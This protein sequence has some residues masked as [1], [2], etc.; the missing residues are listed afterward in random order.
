MLDPDRF[1]FLEGR[2]TGTTWRDTPATPLPINN[3][4]VLHLLEALQIEGHEDL[5]DYR[6]HLLIECVSRLRKGARDLVRMRYGD[7]L[8]F[9]EISKR[10]KKSGAALRMMMSRIRRALQECMLRGAKGAEV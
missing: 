2:A 9:D 10:L 3:R 5:I 4:T 7:R 8:T 1:P 6:K